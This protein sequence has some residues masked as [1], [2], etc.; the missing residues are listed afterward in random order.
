MQGQGQQQMAGRGF[1][2]GGGQEQ[3]MNQQ[4][5]QNTMQ[6]ILSGRRD[7][8]MKAA[9]QNR[10]DELGALDA[11]QRLAGQEWDANM[12][13]SQQAL[14]QMNQNRSG[15]LN[16]FLGLH[17]ADMDMLRLDE[18]RNQ[19]NKTYGLDFLRYLQQGDQFNRSFG[20]NQRQYNGTMGLNWS[21]AQSNQ[22]Q[23]WLNTLMGVF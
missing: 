6:Q 22:M 21:N 20:E 8:A 15:N 7:V 4:A 11:S 12:Q 9:Q 18:G 17:G 19:F 13:G 2:A 23:N 3:Q 10:Q 16:D 5:Q 1:G 14:N